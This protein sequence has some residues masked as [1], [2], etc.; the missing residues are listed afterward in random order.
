MRSW[1]GLVIL[2][3]VLLFPNSGARADAQSS[4]VWRSS[5]AG[6]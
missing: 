5:L 4:A 3:G 6:V 2:A 1:L